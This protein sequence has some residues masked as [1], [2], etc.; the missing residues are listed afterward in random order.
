MKPELAPEQ[1]AD[2]QQL[3][4]EI[5]ER[6]GVGNV[7]VE[8]RRWAS[9]GATPDAVANALVEALALEPSDRWTELEPDGALKVATRVLHQ[10]LAYRST[11]MSLEEANA[12]ARRFIASCGDGA[13]FFTNG[14]VAMEADGGAWNPITQATFDSGVIGV[15]RRRVAM[16]W[17]EDED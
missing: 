8:H 5:R 12:L 6:R 1:D 14:T 11:V 9:D 16:L 2:I 7:H 13:T 15:S 3:A 4:E 17:V 10:D